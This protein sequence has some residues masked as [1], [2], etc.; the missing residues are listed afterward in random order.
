MTS[1]LDDIPNDQTELAALRRQVAELKRI[2][3]DLRD[4]EAR[5]VAIVDAAVDA[6]IT[7]DERGQIRSVNT[8]TERMFGHAEDEF[9]GRNIRATARVLFHGHALSS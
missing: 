4:S 9:V 6:I 7:I 1:A 3:Q 8:S 2:E 5:S